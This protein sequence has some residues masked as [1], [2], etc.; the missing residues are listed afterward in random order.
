MH[1]VVQMI[2]THHNSQLKNITKNQNYFFT[3]DFD[4]YSESYHHL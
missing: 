4:R 1:H 2:H 3:Q